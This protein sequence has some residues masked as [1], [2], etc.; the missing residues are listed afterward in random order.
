MAFIYTDNAAT[1]VTRVG[2]VENLRFDKNNVGFNE[3]V[4]LSWDAAEDGICNPVKRYDIYERVGDDDFFVISTTN[5]WIAID[6]P[7]AN[8][9]YSYFVDAVGKIE[10]LSSKRNGPADLVVN[11]GKPSTPTGLTLSQSEA[12]PNAEA[13]LTWRR[14]A[15]G[16]NN[17]VNGYEIYRNG[18]FYGFSV[19]PECV[20]WA[21]PNANKGD[22]YTV[23]A[24]GSATTDGSFDSDMSD[25]VELRAY[26]SQYTDV[27]FTYDVNNPV[28][29]FIVPTWAKRVD[30]CCI[31]GGAGGRLGGVT[32]GGKNNCWP[33][34]GAG[35]GSGEMVNATAVNVSPGGSYTIV[36]GSGGVGET[37]KEPVYSGGGNSSFGGDIVVASGGRYGYR[38]DHEP[39]K[40]NVTA[41]GGHGGDGGIGGNGGG[42][43]RGFFSQNVGVSG[44]PGGDIHDDWNVWEKHQWYVFG[45]ISTNRRLGC[46]GAGGLGY[47]LGTDGGQFARGADIL[48]APGTMYGSGGRG[49]DQQRTGRN[50][51]A[52]NGQPGLVAIRCWRY[53]S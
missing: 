31:G 41:N 5:T 23:K 13:I 30:V 49:G 7:T 14:S 47:D 8:A 26:A 35:G 15:D 11:V 4:T 51:D 53:L 2:P 48:T 52:T 50:F 6:S 3:E 33:A 16:T 36:V 25:A 46:G 40:E 28:Q 27:Y 32:Y 37:V 43:G 17:A 24:R 9:T 21:P 44:D 29:T 42:P 34:G 19:E 45:D 20:V 18:A 38:G 22:K 10:R 39:L 1:V 12:A